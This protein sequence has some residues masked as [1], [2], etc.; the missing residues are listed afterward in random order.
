MFKQ[1]CKNEQIKM[2]DIVMPLR[3]ILCSDSQLSVYHILDILG[4]DKTWKRLM[5]VAK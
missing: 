2:K 5:D 4:Y 3:E 1:F